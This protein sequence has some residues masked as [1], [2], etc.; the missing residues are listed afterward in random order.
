MLRTGSFCHRID[1][2]ITYDFDGNISISLPYNSMTLQTKSFQWKPTKGKEKLLQASKQLNPQIDIS[3]EITVTYM[4]NN[5]LYFHHTVR[6]MSISA[7]AQL[8]EMKIHILRQF[9]PCQIK[10]STED[11]AYINNYNPEF[12]IYQFYDAIARFLYTIEAESAFPTRT[13]A[14]SQVC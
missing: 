7:F 14:S 2:V 3:K 11:T 8:N 6:L 9:D 1:T 13:M 5:L 12:S 4:I 10:H